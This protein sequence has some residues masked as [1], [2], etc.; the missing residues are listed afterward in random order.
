[1]SIALCGAA[2]V[3][4]ILF[5]FSAVPFSVVLGAVAAFFVMRPRRKPWPNV[6]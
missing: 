2:V 5:G 6:E 3:S 4:V 1:M